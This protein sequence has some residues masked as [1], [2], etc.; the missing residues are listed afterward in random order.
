MSANSTP[1]HGNYHGY[2]AKRPAVKDPRLSLLPPELF[3]GASVLDVGCNEGWVTCEIAQ[4][5]GARRVLGVDIDDTLTRLAWKRKRTVWSTQE[6]TAAVDEKL[7]PGYFPASFEHSFGPLPI[8]SAR[9][10]DKHLFPHNVSFRTADWTNTA[11]AQDAAG[12]DVVI[13]FSLTKWIHLNGGDDALLRFFRRVYDVL[14]PGGSLVLEP[15]A[16]ETYA[17]AK[18]MDN[19]LRETAKC[20]KLRP[21][22]FE[23]LLQEIGFGAAQHLGTTGE[24]GRW[25]L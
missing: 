23:S 9:P 25:I 13:A 10:A 2:Y 8:P 14:T 15:Q 6:P 16:W 18:R 7:R 3:R 21:N 1:I 22:D 5:W 12:Y 19:R 11:I 4:S 24:G 17:K 20:L